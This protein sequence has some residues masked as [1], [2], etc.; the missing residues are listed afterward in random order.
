MDWA[1]HLASALD[2]APLEAVG[3]PPTGV[4]SGAG[5]GDNRRWLGTEWAPRRPKGVRAGASEHGNACKPRL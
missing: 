4:Q 5:M 3:Q 2:G 1:T